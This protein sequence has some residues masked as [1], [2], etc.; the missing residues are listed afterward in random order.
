VKQQHIKKIRKQGECPVTEGAE[1]SRVE[2]SPK[3]EERE[4]K[5]KQYNVNTTEPGEGKKGRRT[6]KTNHQH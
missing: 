3:A 6:R 5:Q 2:Q 4:R 1:Q